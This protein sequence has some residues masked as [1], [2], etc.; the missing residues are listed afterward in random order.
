MR[1]AL[2]SAEVAAAI[3][4]AKE[5]RSVLTSQP[6]ALETPA[7]RPFGLLKP[8]GV[9]AGARVVAGLVAAAVH[10]GKSAAP[11]QSVAAVGENGL[12]AAVAD[13]DCAAAEAAAAHDGIA[14]T[15]RADDARAG[16]V[17]AC[18][19]VAACARGDPS[20]VSDFSQP[21]DSLLAPLFV[22]DGTT[23]NANRDAPAGDGS[24]GKADM[25]TLAGAA[26]LA[27]SAAAADR[28]IV[29]GRRVQYSG[30]MSAE[31]TCY[32]KRGRYTLALA[33]SAAAGAAV[34]DD[35]SAASAEIPATGDAEEEHA[36]ALHVPPGQS[37]APAFAEA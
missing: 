17:L 16:D 30:S 3:T 34:G 37:G 13:G 24:E 7:L 28:D 19:H 36:G 15:A 14:A 4:A 35:R 9:P 31:H 11:F 26:A 32:S 6:E 20:G 8:F 29:A 22:L 12:T 2:P 23:G 18:F 25:V 10:A 1:P 5:L 21:N 33:G 27:A